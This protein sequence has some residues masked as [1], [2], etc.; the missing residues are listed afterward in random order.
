VVQAIRN[1]D[2]RRVIDELVQVFRKAPDLNL[3]VDEL[4]TIFYKDNCCKP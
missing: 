2:E 1:Q 4:N 3:T